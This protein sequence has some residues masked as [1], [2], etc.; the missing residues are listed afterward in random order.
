MKPMGKTQ[1][2]A[3]GGKGPKRNG[4]LLKASPRHVTLMSCWAWALAALGYA[5]PPDQLELISW[6][7]T[8]VSLPSWKSFPEAIWCGSSTHLHDV[9]ILMLF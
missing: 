3:V 9:I 8:P 7:Q 2:R 5:Q 6:L 4:A 1:L